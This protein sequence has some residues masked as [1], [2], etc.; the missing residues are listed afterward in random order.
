MPLFKLPL[1]GDVAQ[2]INPFTS[3]FSPYGSQLGLININLGRS[4][5]PQVEE[6]VLMDVGSYGKQLGRI[7]DAL[8]VLL[9]HFEP[10]RA[11]TEREQQ[12]IDEVKTMLAEIDAVKKRHERPCAP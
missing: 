9:A 5:A 11:L 8:A 4:S 12:A 6:E 7:G 3:F 2:T 10:R 1:S